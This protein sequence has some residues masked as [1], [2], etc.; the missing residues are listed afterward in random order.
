MDED[1]SPRTLP[2]PARA[3]L[4]ACDQ[5][6]QGDFSDGLD[7]FEESADEANFKKKV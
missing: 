4:T 7:E 5:N 6:S 3:P 1:V 2:A